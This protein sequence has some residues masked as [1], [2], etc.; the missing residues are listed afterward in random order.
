MEKLPVRPLSNFHPYPINT[1]TTH[2]YQITAL[3]TQ[4]RI[5]GYS[6]LIDIAQVKI[7]MRL[8]IIICLFN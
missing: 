8:I 5:I 3:Q 6:D 7:S 1:Y 4:V 2:C